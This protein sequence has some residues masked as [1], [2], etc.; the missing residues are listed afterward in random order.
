M[1]QAQTFDIMLDNFVAAL[2]DMYTNAVGR[3]GLAGLFETMKDLFIQQMN[4]NNVNH[5]ALL[6]HCNF[7]IH[8]SCSVM[9]VAE[10]STSISTTELNHLQQEAYPPPFFT[11][12]LY[13]P[14]GLGNIAP[15]AG[16][17]VPVPNSVALLK[18]IKRLLSRDHDVL[19][20]AP[21]IQKCKVPVTGIKP[22]LMWT[23]KYGVAGIMQNQPVHNVQPMHTRFQ[24]DGLIVEVVGK[25]DVWGNKEAIR[26]GIVAAINTL[27]FL[28]R[29]YLLIIHPAMAELYQLCRNPQTGRID[30]VKEHYKIDGLSEVPNTANPGVIPPAGSNFI[31]LMKRCYEAVLDCFVTQWPYIPAAIVQHSNNGLQR[32]TTNTLHQEGRDL[33]INCWNPTPAGQ[34]CSYISNLNSLANYCRADVGHMVPY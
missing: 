5:A 18:C 3:R 6:R 15:V 34:S 25:K 28:E 26:K 22:D 17:P 23:L 14:P 29:S 20:P 7:V 11:T 24:I 4:V 30:I 31:R 1:I 2:D 32:K 12:H 10:I 9:Q 33:Q 16:A 13:P 21:V 19:C 27:A 8:S